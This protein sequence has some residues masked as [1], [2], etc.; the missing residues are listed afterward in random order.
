MKVLLVL[1]LVLCFLALGSCATYV[2]ALCYK[3]RM[4][5]RPP[6]KEEWKIM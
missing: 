3:S 4:S 6:T 5:K 2:V 1:L